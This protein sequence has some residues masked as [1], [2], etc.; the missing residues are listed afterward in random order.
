MPP[1]FTQDAGACNTRATTAERIP[2]ALRHED[3]GDGL[4]PGPPPQEGGRAR[5]KRPGIP[6]T[7]HRT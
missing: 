1:S 5:W 2:R 3:H 6:A 4:P 7:L